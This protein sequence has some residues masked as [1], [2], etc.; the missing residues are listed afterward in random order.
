REAAMVTRSF[1][2]TLADELPVTIGETVFIIE[3]FDDGWASCSNIGG[4]C[5]VVPL[6]C[7]QSMARKP[8]DQLQAQ[9]AGDWRTSKRVSSL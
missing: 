6:E 8:R 7:L 2:P 1:M 5:G 9:Q 3:A 4:Q